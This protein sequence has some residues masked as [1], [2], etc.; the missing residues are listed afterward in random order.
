[1]LKEDDDMAQY[2]IQSEENVIETFDQL[3]QIIEGLQDVDDT[4][5]VNVKE[6]N[7]KIMDAA[8]KDGVTKD[9]HSK[10]K[11]QEFNIADMYRQKDGSMCY[12][13]SK[14]KG[15]KKHKFDKK[16]VINQEEDFDR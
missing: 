2:M 12:M 14:G 10:F 15:C 9:K 4:W 11:F 1:M 3:T 7:K 6:I 13:C 5:K 8:I 16:K